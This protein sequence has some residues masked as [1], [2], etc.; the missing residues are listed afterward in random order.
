MS[1]DCRVQKLTLGI[2]THDMGKH[3]NELL[4]SI[5]LQTSND[6]ELLIVINGADAA[7]FESLETFLETFKCSQIRVLKN[8]ENLGSFLGTKQLIV[9]SASQYLSIIHGDDL[10]SP[11][12]IETIKK[13]IAMYPD[14]AAIN[15][16]L[17]E[18][19]GKVENSTGNLIKS[20][21]TRSKLINRLLV[22]SLNPGIMPGS[23]VNKEY[24][25]A[26]LSAIKMDELRLNGV[27]DVYLWQLL[28]RSDGR[29][30]R[31]PIPVYY[32]RRHPGQISKNHV[33]MAESLGYLRWVNYQSC[34]SKFEKILCMAEIEHENSSL[35]L[36]ELYQANLQPL[37][38]LNSYSR[39]RLI[40][41][42][43][44][45]FAI[46]LNNSI[47]DKLRIIN[48]NS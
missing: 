28:A 22:A 16:D 5:R 25:Q 20:N 9:N 11:K 1:Y 15:F 14:A 26:G 19:Y 38:V 42:I 47:F 40:N 17:K 33:S 4:D 48:F 18:F 34:N 35:K 44:R 32:Y 43:L 13:F 39:F 37:N 29:I 36:K 7:N 2:L 6:F 21:W 27:E 31:V 30:I 46:F 8:S 3:F 45:R 41:I 10:L 12:Y 23:V 24:L